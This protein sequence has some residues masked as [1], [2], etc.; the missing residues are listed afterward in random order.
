MNPEMFESL[1]FFLKGNQA[2]VQLAL[3]LIFL[4]H[5]VDDL[6]DKDVDRSK[7]DIKVTFKKLFVDMPHNPFYQQFYPQLSTL[8]ASAYLMW[9]NSTEFE[10]GDINDKFIC[11]H[12]RN[13]TMNIINHMIFLVGGSDWAE[14]QGASFWKLFSPKI[15]KWEEFLQE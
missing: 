8:I 11:F 7:E 15:E 10:S 13:A 5:S 1:S 3:D 9:C 4:A 12:I 2:A 14:S 6:Y